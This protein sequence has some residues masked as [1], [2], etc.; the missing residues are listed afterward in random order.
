MNKLRI[1]PLAFVCGFLP[2][3]QKGPRAT[4]L[5]KWLIALLLLWPAFASAACSPSGDF[6]T[7]VCS[8]T[9]GTATYQ[10]DNEWIDFHFAGNGFS[11]TG[12]FLLPDQNPF[13]IF[14]RAPGPFA[15]GIE[16]NADL[17]FFGDTP[18]RPGPD[19]TDGQRGPATPTDGRG[20]PS[21]GHVFSQQ[22]PFDHRRWDFLRYLS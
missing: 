13:P 8:I 17:S 3:G 18:P 4:K 9:S 19:G 15:L 2:S 20:V 22:R 16:L 10:F 14:V 5:M 1:L 6:L 21:C 7:Q 11:G 12:Y